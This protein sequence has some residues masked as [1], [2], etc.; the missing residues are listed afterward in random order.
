MQHRRCPRRVGQ[1]RN[2]QGFL[3]WVQYRLDTDLFAWS[4]EPS[5]QEDRLL[6]LIELV[7][8]ICNWSMTERQREFEEWCSSTS[9]HHRQ[10]VNWLDDTC[11]QH[12]NRVWSALSGYASLE[13]A[14]LAVTVGLSQL[15]VIV[16]RV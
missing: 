2:S 16:R 4:E 11:D 7:D 15:L 10:L 5:E 6:A 1:E 12:G 8:D 13:E 9:Y 3:A 14:R